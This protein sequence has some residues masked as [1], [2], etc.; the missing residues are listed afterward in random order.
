MTT[1]ASNAEK[2]NPV[3]PSELKAILVST[4]EFA[5]A[6]IPVPKE[7]VKDLPHDIR[8]ANK[9]RSVRACPTG[10]KKAR[11]V[12]MGQPYDAK[13]S[14]GCGDQEYTRE[15]KNGVLI[16][17]DCPDKIKVRTKNG[18]QTR[19][20]ANYY[21]E[22]PH[23]TVIRG[24]DGSQ[25][26]QMVTLAQCIMAPWGE[27]AMIEAERQKEREEAEARTARLNE[28]ATALAIPRQGNNWH[29]RTG[30]ARDNVFDDKTGDYKRGPDGRA[31]V[32]W[33]GRVEMPI[34]HA[35]KIAKALAD[36]GIT[37]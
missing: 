13:F 19:S 10:L 26:V 11:V 32:R 15:K 36:A 25:R 23:T 14:L 31:I 29:G 4:D 18:T 35:E 33:Q 22:R 12:K 5:V 8:N 20:G 24:E 1:S 37:L 21:K 34:E 28:V 30:F 6:A 2:E 3:Q 16:E 7:G 9:A 27:Y 17:F